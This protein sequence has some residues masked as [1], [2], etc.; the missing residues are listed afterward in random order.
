V[1]RPPARQAQWRAPA[2]PA[3][4]PAPFRARAV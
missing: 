1:E 4:V 3:R 2:G